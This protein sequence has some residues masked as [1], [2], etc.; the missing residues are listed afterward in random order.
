LRHQPATTTI[1]Q[2]C[3]SCQSVSAVRAGTSHNLTRAIGV[4]MCPEHTWK[5]LLAASCMA[6]SCR[7]AVL[8]LALQLPHN[9]SPTAIIPAAATSTCS[10]QGRG[11]VTHQHVLNASRRT[12][13]CY[14]KSTTSKANL[15]TPMFWH[16]VLHQQ[17]S[18]STFKQI[19]RLRMSVCTALAREQQASEH[20]RQP[21]LPWL[22]NL[23]V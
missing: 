22:E 1:S 20:R 7:A 23:D 21:F 19:I 10:R 18:A 8:P 12:P 13:C 3:H 9:L 15:P 4:C 14:R 5:L 17:L 6:G 16:K 11:K 2:S